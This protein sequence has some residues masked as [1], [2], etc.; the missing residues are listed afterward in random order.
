M[1]IVST[2]ARDIIR[3]GLDLSE[4]DITASEKKAAYEEIQ[5][6]VLEYSAL[7]VSHLYIAQV[8][9]QYGI[10]ELENYNKA[11]SEDSKQSQC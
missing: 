10:I 2:K 11:K 1:F 7:K 4:L 8:K 9:Q 6:Y 5:A 3:I